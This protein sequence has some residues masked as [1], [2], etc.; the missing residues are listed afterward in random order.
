MVKK[1]IIKVIKGK[2]VDLT[3]NKDD[4]P[5]IKSLKYQLRR[6]FKLQEDYEKAKRIAR[7]KGLEEP[8]IKF[9][10]GGDDS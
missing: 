4:D 5:V 10:E 3:P 7:K 8:Y 1:P 6:A 9:L 2:E